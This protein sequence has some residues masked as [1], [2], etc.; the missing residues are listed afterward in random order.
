[1]IDTSVF[2][3]IRQKR[4]IF[5]VFPNIDQNR[6]NEKSNDFLEHEINQ[7]KVITNTYYIC[8]YGSFM[9][10]A[11]I[12]CLYLVMLLMLCKLIR[13]DGIFSEAMCKKVKR[14]ELKVGV[15]HTPDNL[16]LNTSLTESF[17]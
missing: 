4:Y 7:S 11:H 10:Q 1:M 5:F 2:S 12:F 14:N 9:L 8:F 13:A 15:W 16:I 17:S 6:K 3:S